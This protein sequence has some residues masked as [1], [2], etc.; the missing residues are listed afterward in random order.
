MFVQ[1]YPSGSKWQVTTSG[2]REPRWTKGGDELVYRRDNTLYA[3]RISRQPFSAGP[4]QTLLGI[5]N[6]F[7][8]DVSADGT[9]FVVSLDAENR[10]EVDF[11]LVTGWFEEL[12]AKMQPPQ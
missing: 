7:G 5:P 1:A 10:E 11:V 8:F 9:R 12:R 4:A 2:G 3:V 6:L